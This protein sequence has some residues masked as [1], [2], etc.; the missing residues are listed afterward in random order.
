MGERASADLL[1]DLSKAFDCLPHDL[2]ITKLH[3]YSIKNRSLNLIISYLKNR[4]QSVRLNNTHTEWIEILFGVPQGSILVPFS[5]DIFYAI[6]F[7]SSMTFLWQTVR[8]TTSTYSFVSAILNVAPAEALISGTGGL[9][10]GSASHVASSVVTQFLD[11]VKVKD[12][13]QLIN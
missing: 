9:A 13:S 3:A 7:C 5:F 8:T 4:K 11:Q 10:L 12:T 6:F 1:N 2:L